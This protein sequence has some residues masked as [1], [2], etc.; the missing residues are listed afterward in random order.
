MHPR[1]TQFPRKRTP[2]NVRSG[3]RLGWAPCLAPEMRQGAL[4][5]WSPGEGRAGDKNTHSFVLLPTL[6]QAARLASQASPDKK[7]VGLGVGG[8]SN[9]NGRGLGSMGVGTY[10]AEW[11]AAWERWKGRGPCNHRKCLK[12]S[13]WP[14][15]LLLP[16]ELTLVYLIRLNG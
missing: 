8:T 13:W 9:A 11:A 7:A 12:A 2:K 15:A 10:L 1:A 16:G 5:S 4:S 14:W 6:A 3:A